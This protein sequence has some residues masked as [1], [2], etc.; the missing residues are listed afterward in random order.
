MKRKPTAFLSIIFFVL[1]IA[2]KTNAQ[3]C[4]AV[5]ST[6]GV[7]MLQHHDSLQSAKG[8]QLTSA[9]RYFRSYKH[10]RGTHEEKNRV[11][12]NSEVINK[13]FSLDLSLVRTFNSRWSLGFNIPILSN[14]RSSKYEHYGNNSTDPAA[15][16]ETHSFGIGDIRVAG[17]YWLLDPARAHKGNVQAG[18]GLKLP[19]G[20]YQVMDHFYK[21]DGSILLGPVDQSI[22]LGDGGTGFTA[23]L[24][25]FYNLTMTTGLYGNFYYLV[26]PRDHNGVSTARGG[27]ASTSS[28]QNGSDVM[29]VPDQYLLRAG[30]NFTFHKLTASVGA[31][32]ECIPVHDLIGESNGFRR[33]GYIISAEPG[34]SY[35]FNRLS[36]FVSVPVAIERNRT[37]SVP[38]KIRTAQTGN[39][40]QGDAAFADY[41]VNVGFNI[42]F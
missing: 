29:S 1:L 9:S 36:A 5:R 32:M 17:Y 24:N 30:A 25:G 26:N 27:T 41:L 28:L 10:F 6:G 8:W 22:Q 31:R 2:G 15:R 16:H 11:E 37:Q 38:D 12:E 34:I 20:D 33:P 21:S 42:R 7:C 4:I 3:G 19:T 18:L 23:E 40:T 13:Q 14:S 39:F 35:Q